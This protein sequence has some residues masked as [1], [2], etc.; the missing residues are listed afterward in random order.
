[1]PFTVTADPRHLLVKVMYYGAIVVAE[2]MTAMEQGSHLLA[3][4]RYRRVL[5]DLSAAT[6]V[7]DSLDRDD[8]CAADLVPSP[9]N[10]RL[11]YVLPP[12]AQVNRRIESIASTRH[13]ALRRFHDEA[14]ALRWLLDDGGAPD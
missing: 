10:S 3:R 13:H 7:P 14:S 8:A 4:T 12:H 6:P 2:R 1:M 9:R 5:V 11:A